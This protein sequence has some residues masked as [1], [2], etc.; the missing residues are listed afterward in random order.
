M[1]AGRS[2]EKAIE[3]IE[4][5]YQVNL[6][7]YFEYAQTTLQPIIEGVD[8]TKEYSKEEIYELLR[9]LTEGMFRSTYN[10]RDHQHRRTRKNRAL[11][12]E[13]TQRLFYTHLERTEVKPTKLRRFWQAVGRFLS[14]ET[15]ER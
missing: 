8:I 3:L 10:L 7:L 14:I 6:S 11:V 5:N 12:D 4:E 2:Y 15:A 13:E 9:E 1:D